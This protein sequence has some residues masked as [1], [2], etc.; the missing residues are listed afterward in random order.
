MNKR[1][2]FLL[3]CALALVQLL[4]PAWMIG[5]SEVVL[6]TGKAFLFKTQPVDPYDAFRGRYVA[7]RID[8]DTM[9]APPGQPFYNKKRAYLTLGV[10]A[11]G[12]ATVEAIGLRPPDEGDY[13]GV[14]INYVSGDVVH[15]DYPFDRYYMDEHLAPEAEYAYNRLNWNPEDEA[16]AYVAVRVRGGYGVLEELYLDGLPVQEY[17]EAKAAEQDKE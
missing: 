16:K 1:T 8:P 2:V 14:D 13:L 7:L 4:V 9:T 10:D 11:D 6:A 15:F 12:F 17:L 5:R 3:F